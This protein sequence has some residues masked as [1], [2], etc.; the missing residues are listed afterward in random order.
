MHERLSSNEHGVR[1]GAARTRPGAAATSV[2]G[3]S[4]EREA[5]GGRMGD[6]RREVQLAREQG[7]D[8]VLMARKHVRSS[9]GRVV[10]PGLGVAS[11]PRADGPLEL[12]PLISTRAR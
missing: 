8:G 3:A 2:E 6:G 5:G 1:G 12:H 9:T 4:G 11:G 10:G 7:L